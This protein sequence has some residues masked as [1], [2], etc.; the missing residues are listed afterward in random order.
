MFRW[1]KKGDWWYGVVGNQV[2]KTRKHQNKLEFEGI[3]EQFIK[4]YFGLSDNLNEIRR[5]TSKDEYSKNA[6][7]EFWGLRIIRQDPWE[8][9]ISYVCATYKSIA[10]IRHMLNNISKKFGDRTVF[11]G[12]DY[13]TFPSPQ[14]LSQAKIA[15]LK[16]AG[17]GYRAKYV[18]ETSKRIQDKKFDLRGLKDL[19][20]EQAKKELITLPGVGP[21]VA[22]CILLFSQD[23]FEAFPVDIWVKRIVLRHYGQCFPNTFVK[24]ASDESSLSTKSYEVINAFG[25]EYFGKY[26]GYAQEYLFHYERTLQP[27]G[28][29]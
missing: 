5:L 19:Q 10:A 3:N 21:K 6:F 22:D 9:L 7:Q 16:D 27:K 4:D 17:L 25:R 12:D 28:S 23:K 14:K 29:K 1:D 18:L 13:Y 15:D 8:C 26:A 24:K 20:Y 11:E 2:F